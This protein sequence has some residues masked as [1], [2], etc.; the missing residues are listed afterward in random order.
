MPDA[1]PVLTAAWIVLLTL[2]AAVSDARGGT[3]P[4][5]LTLPTLAAA[6]LVAW[7]LVGSSAF[8]TALAGA[9]V[10]GL[11]PLLLFRAGAGGGGDV[12]LLAALGALGGARIGLEI[13]LTSF[14]LATFWALGVL[15]WRR[16]LW[17]A[18][19][20]ALLLLAS[21]VLPASLRARTRVD[22]AALTTVRLGPAVLAASVAVLA[23]RN[24]TWP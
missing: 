1:L 23:A 7:W 10:C 11:V 5:W 6:P 8:G 17:A 12:K 19:G 2:P 14:M 16:Q 24:A 21:P 4:N 15:A 3:I 13:Q 9:L 22:P 18:L 20:R